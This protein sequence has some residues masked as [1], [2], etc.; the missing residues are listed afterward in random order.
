MKLKI[1]RFIESMFS[2]PAA[3]FGDL[4]DE[5]DIELHEQLR[6]AMKDITERTLSG[7]RKPRGRHD[8]NKSHVRV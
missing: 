2:R 5:I 6:K 3:Y 8:D 4:A 1:L 7:G